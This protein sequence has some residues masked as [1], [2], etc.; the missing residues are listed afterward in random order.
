MIL[1][2]SR[3]ARTLALSTLTLLALAAGASAQVVGTA[4]VTNASH[5]GDFGAAD[6]TIVNI[7]PSTTAGATF[8]QIRYSGTLTSVISGTYASEAYVDFTS[9]ALS[10]PQFST[11][12]LKPGTS[13]YTSTTFS[14][15]IY[16]PGGVDAT[17]T[18]TLEHLDSFDDGDGAD[19]TSTTSY[20]F[21]RLYTGSW[22]EASGA[23]SGNEPTFN[24]PSSLTTLSA[25]GTSVY[26]DVQEFV[27][28]TTGSYTIANASGY[29]S[30]LFLYSGAFN[31]SSPLTGLTALNDETGNVLRSSSFAPIDPDE[32]SGG[33]AL[34]TATLTAGTKYYL[35]TSSYDNGQTGNYINAYVGPGAIQFTNPVP[36]PA[37]MVALGLGAAAL[38]RRRRAK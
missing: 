32:G 2:P 27:V 30:Y 12:Q 7:T 18:Y 24:R 25:I 9:S 33:T 31:A 21:D 17:A 22:A 11:V 36:E 16:A 20:T 34:V 6:N 13:A 5:D 14:G 1:R 29:D 37:S 28:G 26:Y 8:R 4:T 38:L 10:T 15:T 19:S 35:V 3:T 23:L